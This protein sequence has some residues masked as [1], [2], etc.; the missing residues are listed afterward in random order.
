MAFSIA[1]APVENSAVFFAW[2][3]G[4]SALSFSASAM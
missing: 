2:L 1:S 4:V 3:P